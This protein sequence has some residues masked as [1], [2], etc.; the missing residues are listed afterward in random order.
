[1]DRKGATVNNK[2]AASPHWRQTSPCYRAELPLDLPPGA[3][4]V[5]RAANNMAL[6]AAGSTLFTPPPF[7]GEFP[8][9]EVIIV[10]DETTQDF[11]LAGAVTARRSLSYF[12]L[13]KRGRFHSVEVKQP[14]IAPDEEPEEL[15][16]LRGNDWRELLK[17]YARC[18]AERAGL[19]SACERPNISGYCSWYYYYANVTENDMAENLS[20]IT[21]PA[22]RQSFPADYFQI[23]DG[24]QPFHGD[25][26]ERNANWPTPLVETAAKISAVNLRPGIWIMPFMASTSSQIFRE[27]PEYFVTDAS[28]SPLLVKGWSPPPNHLWACLD[29]TREDVRQHL[30]HIFRTFREWGFTFFKLDG[31]GFAL[32]EG[33]HFSEKTETAVSMYRKGLAAI[34]EAV[35]DATLLG[36]GAP[37]LPSLGFIDHCRIANDTGMEYLPE[38]TPGNAEPNAAYPCIAN[39]L[40]AVMANWWRIDTQFRADPDALMARQDRAFYTAG[41]ARLSILTGILTG[42]TVT[43]DNFKTIT[44][45]RLEL[46]AKAART[47]LFAP[48]PM[49]WQC[50]AWCQFFS[51]TYNGKYAVAVFNDSSKP[52]LCKLSELGFSSGVQEL[53]SGTEVSDTFQ[54][55]PHDGAFFY[56]V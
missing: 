16:V 24:Y 34:R 38:N 35:P 51:G 56:D 18:T 41:E 27:H 12:T 3:A 36:C 42:V 25:W 15:L 30:Q 7:D 37:F 28:G 21:L 10:G 47:R 6:P 20:A 50:D 29:A 32:P 33:G 46:L 4:F 45:E 19:R 55:P 22:V 17:E 9:Q 53:L 2:T 52:L 1:M 26:L 48:L 8:S 14:M 31:L 54:L 49:Q 43:S 5:W 13:I 40:H 44:L 39:A 11:I 23:D